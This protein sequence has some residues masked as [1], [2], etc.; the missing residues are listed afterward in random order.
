MKNRSSAFSICCALVLIAFT[1]F[2]FWYIPSVT[3]LR[4][5]IEEAE[6][7]LETS[8]GRENKQQYEYDKAVEE[9]PQVQADLAEKAPLAEEAE[10][11][12]AELRERKKQLNAEKQELEAQLSEVGIAWEE[13]SD[14]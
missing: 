12:V 4:S 11:K 10:A 1:V 3:S 8:R 13:D 2:M 9:L 6:Q 7:N 14:E 5:S